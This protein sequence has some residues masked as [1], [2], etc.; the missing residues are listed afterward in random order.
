MYVFI[1]KKDIQDYI[2]VYGLKIWQE[3]FSRIINYNV[4]RE[5]NRFLKKKIYDWQ[6]I[7]QSESIPI[8]TPT[9]KDK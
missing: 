6:S 7:Y 2:N 3:E 1:L 4:E 9:P 5:C 8:P